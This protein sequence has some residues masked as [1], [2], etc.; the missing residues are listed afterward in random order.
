MDDCYFDMAVEM[1]ARMRK[2]IERIELEHALGLVY[3]FPKVPDVVPSPSA[4][5]TTD[6][7][8]LASSTD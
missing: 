5:T 8:I 7:T 4:S 1:Q 6:C 3:L 2:A